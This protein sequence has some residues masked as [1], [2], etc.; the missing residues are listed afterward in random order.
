MTVKPVE[1]KNLLFEYSAL[2]GSISKTTL[3]FHHDKHLKTY[4]DNFNNVVAA[5]DDLKCETL[6][7]L[8]TNLSRL[9]PDK[10]PAIRNNGGGVFNHYFYFDT[11]T[12]PK[13]SPPTEVM[14]K[15]LAASFGSE[16]GFYKEFKAAALSQFGSGWA[17]L[18]IDENKKLTI[19]KTANQN[20]PLELGLTPLLTIDVWEHAYYLD[21]QNCRADYIDAYFDIINWSIV[22]GRFLGAK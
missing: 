5:A 22:E 9:A 15:A 13:T 20:T 14:K 12:S 17:W 2:D 6:P 8:L 4:I 18:V 16:D 7:E 19:I 21:Y 11:L 10:E 3:E 1:L